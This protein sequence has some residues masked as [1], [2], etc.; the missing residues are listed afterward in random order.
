MV[1]KRNESNKDTQIIK[2]NK[3]LSKQSQNLNRTHKGDFGK[4]KKIEFD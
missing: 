3:I 1:P 4:D 2:S